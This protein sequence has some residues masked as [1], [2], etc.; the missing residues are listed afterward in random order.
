M[1]PQLVS[2][3]QR[4]SDLVERGHEWLEARLELFERLLAFGAELRSGSGEI[5]FQH[6]L[7]QVR[8]ALMLLLDVVGAPHHLLVDVELKQ[9]AQDFAPLRC[10]AFE[11]AVELALRKDHRLWAPVKVASYEL[12]DA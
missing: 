8:P 4:Y 5:T 6:A 7:K 10:L 1:L 3:W 12:D 9:L 2:L 11:E